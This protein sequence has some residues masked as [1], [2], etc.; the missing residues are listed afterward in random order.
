MTVTMAERRSGQVKMKKRRWWR[1][2]IRR[3]HG[4]K[5]GIIAKPSII[6]DIGK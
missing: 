6:N 1:G 2:E 3:H 5:S 4:I